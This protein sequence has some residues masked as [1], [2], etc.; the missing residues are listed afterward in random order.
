MVP[1]EVII[2]AV[3]ERLSQDDAVNSG[4]LLDGFPRTLAQAKALDSA[5]DQAVKLVI[6]LEV[7]TDVV[8]ERLSSRRVCEGCGRTYSV[9]N[10]PTS[11]WHCDTCGG[12]VVQRADD[13]PEA[14]SRRL[15]L[16]DELTSPLIGWYSEKGILVT[17]EGSGD[18]DIV[19]SNIVKAIHSVEA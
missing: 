11:P 14:I 10:P 5:I 8:L 16:Y 1:D 7:A 3:V 13:K 17:V 18:L 4:Y 9:S 2:G 6:N 15:A 12:D 19:T